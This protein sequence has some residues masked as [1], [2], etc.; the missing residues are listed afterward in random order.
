MFPKLI[1]I[2][3]FYIPTYGALVTTG[4]VLGLFLTVR[5]AA[6]TGFGKE[7]REQMTNLIIYTIIGGVLGSKLLL[8]IVEFHYFLANP[9]E[10]IQ[11]L[12][13][14]GVFYGGLLGGLFTAAWL[15]RKYKLP[16]YRVADVAA[17]HIALGHAI[18]RLGCFSAGCC[19]GK[20]CSLPI[21]VE[22]HSE[23]AHSVV[24]VP[25]NTPIFPTQL[26]SS[27]SLFV[28]FLVLRFYFWPRRKFQGEMIWLY[29]LIYSAFRFGIEFFR[30][31]FV[32]GFVFNLI[33]TSQ[34]ISLVLFFTAIV[35]LFRLSRRK[36]TS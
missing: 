19:Y 29:V 25:L 28:I 2:G 7:E 33:S 36:R 27:I 32:R 26:M 35:M 34:F 1:Q 11:V 5:L 23:F 16:F 21:A 17:P 13:S 6:K 9:G 22:F 14:G 8:V 24:G 10:L 18:G 15:F 31:D 12:R 20:A 4:V 3:S 30:G